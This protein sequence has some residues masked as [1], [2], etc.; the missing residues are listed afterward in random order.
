MGKKAT[1]RKQIGKKKKINS[2]I[3]TVIV[4]GY[5]IHRTETG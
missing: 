5:C 1:W 2:N 3:L 4:R